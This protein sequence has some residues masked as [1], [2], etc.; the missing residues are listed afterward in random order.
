MCLSKNEYICYI[1]K[2][3]K[4]NKSRKRL[5]PLVF[6][7][8]LPNEKVCVISCIEECLK[9][10][11]SIREKRKNRPTQLLLSYPPP[12]NPA[13]SSTIAWYVKLFLNLLGIV[14]TM[15][16]AHSTKNSSFSRVENLELSLKNIQKAVG[17]SQSSTLRK[18]FKL[19]FKN[20][21]STTLLQGHTVTQK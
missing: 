8:F 6:E 5:P 18:F 21:C 16:T 15:Y 2:V 10:T 13:H 19:P 11:K 1:P 4:T 12:H 7:K 20:Y 3:L 14:M 17:W 9:K